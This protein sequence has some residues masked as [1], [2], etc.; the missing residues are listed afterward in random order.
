MKAFLLEDDTAADEEAGQEGQAQTNVEAIALPEP[1]LPAGR[2]DIAG[3]LGA[4]VTDD[5]AQ[6][7]LGGAVKA[8]QGTWT[9]R[10]W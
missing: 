1:L 4:E 8:D 9:G 10:P 2:G 3:H 7:L 6:D 5:L